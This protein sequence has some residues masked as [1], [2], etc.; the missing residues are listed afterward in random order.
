MVE[1]TFSRDQIYSPAIL[2]G[3][4]VHQSL[5]TPGCLFQFVGINQ[6]HHDQ[7]VNVSINFRYRTFGRRSG[8]CL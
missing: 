5:R 3:N 8:P 7:Q 1:I 6:S 2:T 4:F